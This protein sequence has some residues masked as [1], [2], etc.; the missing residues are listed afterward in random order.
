MVVVRH[1]QDKLLNRDIGNFVEKS[2][3]KPLFK[4]TPLK[5]DAIFFSN[6]GFALPASTCMVEISHCEKYNLSRTFS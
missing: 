2:V 6:D 1:G 4:N 5:F 3:C